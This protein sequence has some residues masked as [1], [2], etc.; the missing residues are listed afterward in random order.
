MTLRADD[1]QSI[2]KTFIM[3]RVNDLAI[4]WRFV[5]DKTPRREEVLPMF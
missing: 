2:I 5:V 4:S 1:K 3:F